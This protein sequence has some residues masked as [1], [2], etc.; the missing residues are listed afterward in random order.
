MSI[1]A[2]SIAATAFLAVIA[3]LILWCKTKNSPQNLSNNS[4]EC[5]TK[6][7]EINSKID[8]IRR[9]TVELEQKYLNE[10]KGQIDQMDSELKRAGEKMDKM[11][12]KNT[13]TQDIF[14]DVTS[15]LENIETNRP[16]A[17]ILH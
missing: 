17:P 9:N 10:F 2:V 16:E 12:H 8:A 7:N 15:R 3:I 14:L 6:I 11:V 5:T 13:E 1:G 4:C